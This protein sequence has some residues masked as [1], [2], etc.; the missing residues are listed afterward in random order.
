MPIVI[1]ILYIDCKLICKASI[2]TIPVII[3]TIRL[4]LRVP[5]PCRPSGN[6]S[7]VK[8]S[9]LHHASAFSPLRFILFFLRFRIDTERTTNNSSDTPSVTTTVLSPRHS[10]SPCRPPACRVPWPA[11]PVARPLTWNSRTD[12]A[13]WRDAPWRD[14]HL[15]SNRPSS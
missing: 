1:N 9:I 13:T 11:S 10:Q 12:S 7:V 4:P 3:V 6:V 5:I 2:F 14:D 8:G 15:G